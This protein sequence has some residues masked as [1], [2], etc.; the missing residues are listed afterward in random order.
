MNFFKFSFCI[1]YTPIYYINHPNLFMNGMDILPSTFFI[2]TLHQLL[3]HVQHVSDLEQFI[4]FN[5]NNSSTHLN[6]GIIFVVV[7]EEKL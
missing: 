2:H 7:V 4:W 5:A 1:L 3:K 6:F